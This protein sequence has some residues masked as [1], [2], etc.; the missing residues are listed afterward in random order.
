MIPKL[1]ITMCYK[2]ITGYYWPAVVDPFLTQLQTV[3]FLELI[4]NDASSHGISVLH[5]PNGAIS[6]VQTNPRQ[7]WL[8][9][10]AHFKLKVLVIS[11]CSSVYRQEHIKERDP[12]TITVRGCLSLAV[13]VNTFNGSEFITN[14]TRICKS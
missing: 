14:K 12:N 3:K 7:I 1:A 4:V 8:F 6:T 5:S 11:S 2:S 10:L 9:V 13:I